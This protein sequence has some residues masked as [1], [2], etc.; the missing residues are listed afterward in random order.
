M[1]KNQFFD[2]SVRVAA[3]LVEENRH[4]FELLLADTFELDRPSVEYDGR[5]A[6]F[7]NI[8]PVDE[9]TQEPIQAS[10]E[11]SLPVTF[12]RI[13]NRMH[14]VITVDNAKSLSH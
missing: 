10:L 3:G 7:F 11:S 13:A 9:K 6:A 4:L 1:L 12:A 2:Q 5:S 14:Q 8:Q